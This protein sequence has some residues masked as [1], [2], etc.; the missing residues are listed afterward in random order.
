MTTHPRFPIRARWLLC[1]LL[2]AAPPMTAEAQPLEWTSH[3]TVAQGSQFD[4]LR[5]PDGHVHLIT[6]RYYVFDADGTLLGEEDPGDGHQGDLDFPPAIAVDDEGAV[7]IVT[8]HDGDFE[9]GNDIR[10]RRRAADGSWDRDYL[11]GSRERRNYVVGVT[12]V[13]ARVI[14]SHTVAGGDV[15]GDVKLWEAGESGATALGS[16]G[17]IWRADCGIRMRTNGDRMFVASGVPDPDGRAYLLHADAGGDLTGTLAANTWEHHDGSG[18]RG[19]TDLRV[20]G[21]GQAHLTYGAQHTVHYNRYDAWGQRVFVDDIQIGSDL[22]DWH[23]SAGLSAVGA[24]DDGETVVAV[25]LRSDGSQQAS[26]S[27]LLWSFSLDGGEHWSDPEDLGVN[28]TGGEGRLMPRIVAVGNDFLLFYKDTGNGS[29][30]LMTMYVE[31]DD[32]GDG[33]TSDVDCDDSDPTVHPGAVEDCEDGID[34]DCD[35]DTDEEDTDCGGTGDDDTGGDDDTEEDDDTGDDDT[36]GDDDAS[37]PG[38]G[39]NGGCECGVLA[40]A[41]SGHVYTGIVLAF[42]TVLAIRRGRQQR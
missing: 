36:A 3:G 26:N 19:F 10:Y 27:D 14:V 32:D 24:S 6:S 22:G 5:G 23:M 1:L 16:L 12:K 29:I 35:G 4:A 11:V 8:R 25:L 31:R 34:N 13:G 20:D 37:G 30:S 7:H 42:I 40:E 38:G 2:C 41:R 9:G 39:T 33:Y 15:W 28:T 18:R 21:Q 17:G